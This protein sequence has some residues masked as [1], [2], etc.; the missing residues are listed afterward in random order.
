MILVVRFSSSICFRTIAVNVTP[1]LPVR[2]GT[3]DVDVHPMISPFVKPLNS[4]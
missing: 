3:A 1:H 4:H 2:P